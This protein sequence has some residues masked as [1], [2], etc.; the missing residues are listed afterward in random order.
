MS[1]LDELRKAN[2]TIQSKATS[3]GSSGG[4]SAMRQANAGRVLGSYEGYK[5][6]NDMQKADQEYQT[7]KAEY[8]KGTGFHP[9]DSFVEGWKSHKGADRSFKSTFVEG[10]PIKEGG[11]VVSET[12]EDQTNRMG[13]AFR[14]AVEG[15][16]NGDVKKADVVAGLGN[17]V[18]GIVNTGFSPIAGALK[19]AES[20]PV[21]GLVA[22]GLNKFA[23]GLAGTGGNAAVATLDA[24][25]FDQE[26][27]E[28]LTPLANEVGS[29]V[30]MLLGF[31]ATEKAGGRVMNS[32]FV[33]PRVE[34]LEMKLKEMGDLIRNDPKLSN[35]VARFVAEHGPVRNVPVTSETPGGRQIPVT[36][37]QKHGAY[38]EKMGYEAYK[39]PRT[40]PT[41][42][43][44][45]G[46]TPKED[47]SGLPVIEA[48]EGK[49]PVQESL[50][51]PVAKDKQDIT[52]EPVKESAVASPE[53]NQLLI[54]LELAEAGRRNFTPQEG[55]MDYKVTGQRSTFPEW[56]P[57]GTRTSKIRNQY[58]KDRQGTVDD[59][60]IKYKEGSALDRLDKA[61]R[62]REEQMIR[63]NQA[64]IQESTV[65]GK[66]VTEATTPEAMSA[67]TGPDGLM[68]PIKGTGE[69]R[70]P[71]LTTRALDRLA[72]QTQKAYEG[73]NVPMH[74][75]AN[76]KE[77]AGKVVDEFNR[78]PERAMDIAMGREL[79]PPGSDTLQTAFWVE[80][81]NR[82][83]A[84]GDAQL[85]LDLS[86]S[87]VSGFAT[88]AGQET[89][90]L[91]NLNKGDA[92]NLIKDIGDTLKKSFEERSGKSAK[93]E[94]QK[95]VALLEKF[96]RESA[97]PKE[98]WIEV[99]K[100][101]KNC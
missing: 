67:G 54:E 18:M 22:T 15:Y 36:P 69:T 65:N 80:A 64:P 90:Y 5:I 38:A 28:K 75:R 17:Y 11:K 98:K 39:D 29:L 35:E 53:Y 37:N 32:R 51:T 9:I 59:I 83:E 101:I 40:L 68:Q 27:T 85:L 21:L 66:P 74:Q 43:M 45:E 77:I 56:M 96:I 100:E 55:T 88:R 92:V 84:K 76:W 82:A 63:E 46:K 14:P 86:R 70:N 7:Q 50:P 34:K 57:E 1:A 41:I 47:T 93:E 60:Q 44:G 8:E 99:I 48:G 95:E 81:I 30:G 16:L 25:P 73:S 33:K 20:I 94:T 62:A 79:L 78:D 24:L 6:R 91:A 2:P 58:L 31:K 4:L 49:T 97:L 61:V 13:S 23:A 71:T 42:D 19:G 72:E 3:T 12:L 10:A 52:Y 89:G 87:E 26:T